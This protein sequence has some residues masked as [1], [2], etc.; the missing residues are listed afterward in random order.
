MARTNAA[1]VL[2]FRCAQAVVATYPSIG[3][4]TAEPWSRSASTR[5]PYFSPAT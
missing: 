3:K 2:A 1:A 5:S 4:F